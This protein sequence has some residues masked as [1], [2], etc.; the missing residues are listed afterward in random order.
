[1]KRGV[2]KKVDRAKWRIMSLQFFAR[3]YAES[4]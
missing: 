4:R 1:M 2:K 3:R